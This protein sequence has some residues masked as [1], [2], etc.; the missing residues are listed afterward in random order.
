VAQ[1]VHDDPG[2]KSKIRVYTIGSW[3]TAQDPNAR[4]YLYNNHTDLWW[5]E[6]DTTFRGMYM[7]GIQTGDYGNLTF[8]SAHVRYHGAL[9]DFFYSKKTDIKMGDTP[10]VLYLLHG[11][12]NN[13]ETDSWGGRFVKTGHASNYWHDDPDPAYEYNGRDGAVTVNMWRKD[14]LDDWEIRMDWAKDPGTGNVPPS[15]DAGSNQTIT[16][17]DNDVNLNGTVN[18]PD[19]Y[20]S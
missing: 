11:D 17:P 15:V 13:P 16:L 6:N 10:S 9:G 1:A 5:I 18:D 14:Y 4:N 19:D 8:V 12:A 20:S 7:G 3:N 2:I